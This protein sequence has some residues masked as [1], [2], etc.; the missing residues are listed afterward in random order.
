MCS[1]YVWMLINHTYPQG[2]LQAF[3]SFQICHRIQTYPAYAWW[4]GIVKL[5]QW[6]KIFSINNVQSGCKNVQDISVVHSHCT[7][8]WRVELQVHWAQ[9]LCQSS[10]ESIWLLIVTAASAFV[11]V[12]PV[13]LLTRVFPFD[14]GQVGRAGVADGQSLLGHTLIPIHVHEV[15]RHRNLRTHRGQRHWATITLPPV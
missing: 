14:V 11:C 4:P 5:C 7:K 13:V 8:A 12:G 6:K 2:T 3:D 15:S 10:W 1:S 9:M